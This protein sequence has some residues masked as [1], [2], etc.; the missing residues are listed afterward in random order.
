MSPTPAA[1]DP[2]GRLVGIVE[3]RGADIKSAMNMAEDA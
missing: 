3:R 2:D 1:I